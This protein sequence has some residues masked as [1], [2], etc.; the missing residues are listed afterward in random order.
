MNFFDTSE[1]WACG[2]GAIDPDEVCD[3]ANLDA[4][5]CGSLGFL[6]GVLACASDCTSYDTTSC[7]ACDDGLQ[8]GDET[9]IDCGS[10][11]GPTCNPG[12]GCFTG[13]DCVTH[14]CNGE[15]NTCNDVLTVEVV[16][17]C[18]NYDGAPAVLTAI[19]A[20]GAG[21]YEF[22]WAPNDGTLTA[23]DQA[24]TGASPAGQQT[25][26]VTVED[27]FAMA[28][29]SAR[30]VNA[31][32]LDLDLGCNVYGVDNYVDQ[33]G[34]TRTCA[35]ANVGPGLHLCEGVTMQNVRLRATMQV[36]GGDDDSMGLVW[37]AQDQSHFYSLAWTAGG[38]CGP[39]GIVV[40]RVQGPSFAIVGAN[41]VHCPYDTAN[42][43]FLLGPLET[44]SEPWVSGS[45]VTIDFTE[46]GSAV[47]VVRTNDGVLLA[48]FFVGDTTF[49]SGYFGTTTY[50]QANACIGPLTAECL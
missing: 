49:T 45:E 13:S 29:D 38:I 3:G 6:G 16:P 19:A 17:A 4:A 18:A 1:C 30:V 22:A 2:D 42:S 12:E 14:G 15:S 8:N 41:D 35:A 21:S 47:T 43:S 31:I 36:N 26:T 39:A 7:Y 25:Y 37:G 33:L 40:K 28:Q 5:S 20:G 48:D 32:P 34:G 10:A 44:T 27:G 9:D 46:L 23:L 50:S 24:V 11:C